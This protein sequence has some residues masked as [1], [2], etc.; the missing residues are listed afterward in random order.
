MK[1]AET[2][3]YTG[4]FFLFL[5]VEGRVIDEVR[6]FLLELLFVGD[7]FEG[8]GGSEILYVGDDDVI[9][10]IRRFADEFYARQFLIG[11]TLELGRYI[12][13]SS[14]ERNELIVLDMSSCNL[15]LV[16]MSLLK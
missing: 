7:A 10:P 14:A 8:E 6:I 5:F 9:H 3:S 16:E 12:Y 11:R 2:I 4:C 13:K 15:F 1:Y